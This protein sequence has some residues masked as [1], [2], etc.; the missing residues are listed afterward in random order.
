MVRRTAIGLAALVGVVGA[1]AGFAGTP[2]THAASG[3]SAPKRIGTDHPSVYEIVTHMMPC[4]PARAAIAK[5][6]L[7]GSGNL[8]TAGFRC[9]IVRR[10]AVGNVTNGAKVSCRSGRRQFTFNWAT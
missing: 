5:G 4:S 2:A 7:S 6:R 1:L 8:Q 10:Y 9:H 3:C